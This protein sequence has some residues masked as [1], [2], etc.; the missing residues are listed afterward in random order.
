MSKPVASNGLRQDLHLIADLIEPH[1]RVLDIGCADGALLAYLART[2][3]V[4]ARGIELSQEG[5]HDCVSQGLAVVQGDGDTDLAIYP[6]GS[7]DYVILSQTIQAMRQPHLVLENMLRIGRFGIV[8][9]TNY[10]HWRARWHLLR[11]GRMPMARCLPEPWYRTANIHPCTLEDFEHLCAELGLRIEQRSCLAADGAPSRLAS[12][13]W[14][15]NLLSEQALFVLSRPQ[16]AGA[17]R[18]GTAGRKFVRQPPELAAPAHRPS[19][20]GA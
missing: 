11:R 3:H 17:G 16:Q 18:P 6:D 19:P 1:T 15:D 14:L 2:K 8:S 7:F 9:F 5:V 12:T 13:R 20:D 10:A 4:D